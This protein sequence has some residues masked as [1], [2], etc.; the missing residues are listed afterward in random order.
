M[1]Y[2]FPS[3]K[4]ILV[5]P[6]CP[7]HCIWNKSLSYYMRDLHYSNFLPLVFLNCFVV[8]FRMGTLLCITIFM[9]S[10]HFLLAF[11]QYLFC[12]YVD[13]G[14]ISLCCP[15][16]QRSNPHEAMCIDP[17]SGKQ[18]I[19]ERPHKHLVYVLQIF[20][21]VGGQYFCEV[22]FGCI[23]PCLSLHL[24]SL[25]ICKTASLIFKRS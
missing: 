15:L 14:C 20:S 1:C 18:P 23:P 25:S 11:G 19:P 10:L 22:E 2:T 12:I 24:L 3:I 17:S 4:P 6:F 5:F 16:K 13:H 7:C 9:L 8:V 21:W